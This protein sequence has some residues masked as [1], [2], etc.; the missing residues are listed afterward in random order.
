MLIFIK[1]LTSETSAI[2]RHFIIHRRKTV[3]ADPI[4]NLHVSANPNEIPHQVR[5]DDGVQ[6]NEI[7]SQKVCSEHLQAN[8][9]VLLPV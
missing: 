8:N 1:K 6:D 3:I 2:I 4:R 7:P 5:N 9:I